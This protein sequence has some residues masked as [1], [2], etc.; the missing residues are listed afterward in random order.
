LLLGTQYTYDSKA[1]PLDKHSFAN[2]LRITEKL[3]FNVITD[4]NDSVSILNV[5]LVDETPASLRVNM[6]QVAKTGIDASNISPIVVTAMDYGLA[7]QGD[8]WAGRLKLGD[9]G[10]ELRNILSSHANATALRQ[11]LKR[12]AGSHGPS[13]DYTIPQ[14]VHTA[15]MVAFHS[16]AESK[17]QHYGRRTP[18]YSK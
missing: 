6:T 8:L 18:C 2:G 7:P 1:G 4:K 14:A 10:S 11:A 5:L 15:R 12:Q 3:L 9:L 13:N 17:Q 16:H